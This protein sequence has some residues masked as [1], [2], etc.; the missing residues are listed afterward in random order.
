MNLLH[1]PIDSITRGYAAWLTPHVPSSEETP[2]R[3]SFGSEIQGAAAGFA[4]SPDTDAVD[5]DIPAPLEIA[6]AD[7]ASLPAIVAD[8]IDRHVASQ[9]ELRPPQPG[10]LIVLP[11]PDEHAADEPGHPVAMLL[12]DRAGSRWH[13]WLVGAHVDYAGDRDLVL[14]AS[15]IEGGK[16]PAPIAGMVLCWDSVSLALPAKVRVVHRLNSHA[17]QAI[18]ALARGDF[19]TDAPLAAPAPGRMC[20]REIGEAQ[21]MT[22]TPYLRDDPRTPY[23]RLAREL[24]RRVSEPEYDDQGQVRGPRR[25]EPSR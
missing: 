2:E 1:P 4:P 22:G 14:E 24:A 9:P 13:G 20:I 18:A 12:E 19:G 3:E 6:P 7:D 8:T 11:P 16:D 17:M 5:A 15:L 10:D 25:D 23:L 21:V